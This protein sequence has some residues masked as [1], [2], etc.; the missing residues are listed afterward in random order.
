MKKQLFRKSIVYSLLIILLAV[1]QLNYPADYDLK[2]M[3]PDLLFVFAVLTAY[4]KGLDDGI[5]TGFFGGLIKN[6]FAGRFIG[7]GI[8]IMMYAAIASAFLLRKHL[9]TG[10]PA[11]ILQVIIIS[12][13]YSL[14]TGLAIY[15]MDGTVFA[16]DRFS[17]WWTLNRFL[18]YV[19]SNAVTAVILAFIVKY[20][21]SRK[22]DKENDNEYIRPMEII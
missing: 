18:P 5:V 6:M 17:C 1:I 3:V 14:M 20:L 2:G 9:R 4:F 10:I 8:L 21:P 13:A 7:M 15:V 12:S 16:F 22:S 11:A 19:A